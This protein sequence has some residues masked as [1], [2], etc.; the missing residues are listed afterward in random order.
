MEQTIK[1]NNVNRDQVFASHWLNASV[2]APTVYV[3]PPRLRNPPRG[4][5][6]YR[7]NSSVLRGCTREFWGHPGTSVALFAAKCSSFRRNGAGKKNGGMEGASC[8]GE[9]RQMTKRKGKTKGIV[10]GEVGVM[11]SIQKKGEGVGVGRCVLWSGVRCVFVKLVQLA[12]YRHHHRL[13]RHQHR[14][15][16]PCRHTRSVFY[17]LG[18]APLSRPAA[19]P[20]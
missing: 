20:Y 10:K 14:H 18:V 5:L 19:C 17:Y 1:H 6:G 2:A 4:F 13:Y 16:L 3:T 12:Q 8:R 15:S 11:R 7:S 9:G